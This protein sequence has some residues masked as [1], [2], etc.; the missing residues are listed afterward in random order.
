M[1]GKHHV[2]NTVDEVHPVNLSFVHQ[3]LCDCPAQV[4]SWCYSMTLSRFCAAT[5]PHVVFACAR[6][7]FRQY[8]SSSLKLSGVLSLVKPCTFQSSSLPLISL[9]CKTRYSTTF[10]SSPL[11]TH[12][13]PSTL[14]CP[15]LCHLLFSTKALVSTLSGSWVVRIALTFSG[16][17][18]GLG[19]TAR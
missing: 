10:C 8:S 12:S 19:R 15:F 18:F 2:E 1:T 14:F 11:P 5:C 3:P 16:S 9:F 6:T 4:H 17:H 13:L 7:M